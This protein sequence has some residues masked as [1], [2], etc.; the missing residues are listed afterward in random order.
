[1]IVV[2]NTTPLNYLILIG[3][4][5]LLSAIYS[6]I[7]IP[8]AVYRELTSGRA[9]DIVR[10]WITDRPEW[11]DVADA[12]QIVDAHLESI[13]IGERE[14]ILVAEELNADLIVLDDRK[15]R[16]LAHD[17]GLTVIGTIGILTDAAERGLIDL[18]EALQALQTTSFRASSELLQSLLRQNEPQ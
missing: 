11:V 18:R 8:R 6:N 4:A 3:R 7:V 16:R 15:A 17:R 9:P 14:T 12:P 5:E 1:M 10:Q 13:Q 2:S